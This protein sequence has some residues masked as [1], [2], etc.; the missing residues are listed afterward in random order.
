VKRASQNISAA[1]KP[2]NHAA[3]QHG[4]QQSGMP[5]S[6]LAALL[7]AMLKEHE[8]LLAIAS[9]IRVAIRSADPDALRACVSRQALTLERITDLERERSTLVAAAGNV[10]RLDATKPLRLTDLALATAEPQR[11]QL[12]ALADRVRD[13]VEKVRDEQRVLGAAMASLAGHAEGIMRTMSRSMS[14][15]QTYSNAGVIEAKHGV[16]G[17]LDLKT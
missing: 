15:A 3:S 16:I 1:T 9:D 14:R 8:A 2:A 5:T 13:L 10:K 11:G 7:H 4:F 17:G 6:G 12:V